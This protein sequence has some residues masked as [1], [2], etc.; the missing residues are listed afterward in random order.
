MQQ[1]VYLGTHWENYFVVPTFDCSLV[2]VIQLFHYIFL[3]CSVHYNGFFLSNTHECLS[4]DKS[5][6]HLCQSRSRGVTLITHGRHCCKAT[7]V[8]TAHWR[9]LKHNQ[10]KQTYCNV[11]RGWMSHKQHDRKFDDCSLA[12]CWNMHA[13]R[14][15]DRQTV[16]S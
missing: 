9:K 10:R 1:F 3:F 14:Q 16:S 6:L 2:S 15:T 7:A 12:M 8:I 4:L 11:A 5:Y 13:N